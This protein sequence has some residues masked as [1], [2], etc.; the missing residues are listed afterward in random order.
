MSFQYGGTVNQNKEDNSIHQKNLAKLRRIC[1]NMVE[2][3]KYQVKKYTDSIENHFYINI[4]IDNN[5]LHPEYMCQKCYLLMSSSIKRKTTIKLTPFNE[6]EPHS[7]NWQICNKMKLLQKGIIGT[8]KLKTQKIPLGRTKA[9]TNI[10]TQSALEN[11]KEITLPDL[12]PK[13]LTLKDFAPDINPHLHLCVCGICEN[14]L[15]KPL[16]IKSCQHVFC[17][18]CL[19]SFLKSKPE[20]STFCPTC[21]KQFSI[22]DVSHST[23]SHNMVK[24]LMLSCKTWNTNHSPITEYSIY[25]IHEKEYS[26]STAE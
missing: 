6:W 23:H 1:C 7:T 14:L 25:L 11:L 3:K 16:I 19:S 12:L 24:T 26:L 9:S 8:Q 5:A 13:K 18:L 17:F 21:S 20:D 4:N 10:W 22:N 15:R 2:K